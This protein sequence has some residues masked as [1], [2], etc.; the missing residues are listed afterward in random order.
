MPP[1]PAP[2]RPGARLRGGPLGKRPLATT[3]DEELDERIAEFLAATGAE[4]DVDL[5][6]ELAVAVALLA[7]DG[8]DRA[9]LKIASASLVE[10]RHAFRVFR[11]YRDAPKATMFG[12]AR[13][14]V[15][16]PLYAQ[17][18]EMA[19][20]LAEE[21]WMVVTGA[22]PGI[23]EAGMDGAGRAR[24]F[25]VTIRLPF[26]SGANAVIAGDEK[27]VDM[28][29]FFTRKLMLVKESRAFVALPGGFGTLD[30]TFELLTLMQTGKA[31][32]APIVLLDVPGGTYWEEFRRFVD[33]E[34]IGRGLVSPED[35]ELYLITDD[36]AEARREIVGFWT[37]FDSLRYVGDRL[38]L[39]LRHRP[40]DEEVA[41]LDA[42]FGWLCRRGG[43]TRTDPLPAEVAD[44]DRLDRPRVMLR[45]DPRLVGRLRALI[46][47]LNALPSASGATAPP[48]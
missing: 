25:G 12:S 26:E 29:Y 24:S 16:D 21:G 45:L 20:V 5:L 18:R 2:R 33:G 17:A 44:D 14:R 15:D 1:R 34:L 42:N 46:D 30:E 6:T 7:A 31:A 23:M 19:R 39:R 8:T 41:E 48:A 28:K 3:G 38:V 43:I 9:D 37:N 32:P 36:V 4:R 10:M 35:R 11:P 27:L 40:T 13:T 22:G 47:A